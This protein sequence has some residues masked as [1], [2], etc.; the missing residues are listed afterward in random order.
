VEDGLHEAGQRLDIDIG[1]PLFLEVRGIPGKYKAKLIGMDAGRYLV[2]TM[3]HCPGP[4]ECKVGEDTFLKVRYV[5]GGNVFGFTSYVM[6]PVSH[7]VRLLIIAYPKQVA[8]QSLRK[9]ERFDCYLPCK[10]SIHDANADG[11]IVDISIAGCRCVMPLSPTDQADSHPGIDDA[12]TLRLTTHEAGEVTLSGTIVNT[13]E[14]HGAVRLGVSFG[15]LEPA[16]A[17]ALEKVIMP[18]TM[19]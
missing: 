17:G 16:A 11:T 12:I 2:I 19:D 9:A 4:T 7:P 5:H 18:F 6:G 3:P 1:T 15:K 8:E 14:Y 10:A 13:T